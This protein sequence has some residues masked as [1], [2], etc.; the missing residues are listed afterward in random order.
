M[1][2]SRARAWRLARARPCSGWHG[3]A[4][5]AEYLVLR[6]L[7]SMMRARARGLI[8]GAPSV[9]DDVHA[10]PRTPD[11]TGSPDKARNYLPH[12][13]QLRTIRELI[14]RPD[15]LADPRVARLEPEAFTV[16]GGRPAFAAILAAARSGDTSAAE[17]RFQLERTDPTAP[18]YWTQLELGKPPKR[19]TVDAGEAARQ[20]RE[21]D[22]LRFA[23]ER[24][25]SLAIGPWPGS[26]LELEPLP[27]GFAAI[28]R[29]GPD[30]GV[31][32]LR[33]GNPKVGPLPVVGAP[34]V[35]RDAAGA[36]LSRTF[37]LALAAGEP[38]Q[39]VPWP[40]LAS[41]VCWERFSEP[42]STDRKTTEAMAAAV[43]T[44][45]AELEPVD[46]VPCWRD[47]AP[48]LP[49]DGIGPPGF[50]SL[51]PVSVAEALSTW[52]EI[53]D[54]AAA[55]PKVALALGLALG[56]IYLE[57]LG[58][59]GFTLHLQG[60][61]QRGKSTALK[62]AAAAMG[63]PGVI[64]ESFNSTLVGTGGDRAA[65]GILPQIVDELGTSDLTPRQLEID[66]FRLASG[67]GR[68]RG[69]RQTFGSVRGAGFKMARL[70]SG[71]RRIVPGSTNP[72][73]PVRE[74]DL[75][76][77]ITGTAAAAV[78][79][80]R[81]SE[82]AHG[83][84]FAWLRSAPD[85]AGFRARVDAADL[86]LGESDGGTA[87]AVA[88]S[89]AVC[90][91][92]FDWLAEQV[93]RP[94]AVGAALGAA[95]VKLAELTEELAEF[96]ATLGDQL[97]AAIRDHR[98]ANP[99]RW[100]GSSDA[101]PWG[102]QPVVGWDLIPGQVEILGSG[103]AEIAHAYGLEDT[104]AARRELAARGLGGTR[105]THR[106][107]NTHVYRFRLPELEPDDAPD[108]DESGPI[109]PPTPKPSGGLPLTG[110]AADSISTDPQ[111][112]ADS[113]PP[114]T[115]PAEP[116]DLAA[117]VDA[118]R[119]GPH[120]DAAG[121]EAV[122]AALA[123]TP[124]GDRARALAAAM[125]APDPGPPDLAADLADYLTAADSPAELR[126]RA[127]QTADVIAA[128]PEPDRLAL[129][130]VYRQR[131][132]ELRG[133]TTPT[134]RPGQ[135]AEPTNAP[136]TLP[137]EPAPAPA[138]A[139]AGP[140][141]TPT[142]DPAAQALRALRSPVPLPPGPC[143]ACGGS[144]RRTAPTQRESAAEVCADCRPGVSSTPAPI[145][146][147][148]QNRRGAA[149][150]APTPRE[151]FR[152]PS[153]PAAS[154]QAAPSGRKASSAAPRRQYVNLATDGAALWAPGGQVGEPGPW[155]DAVALALAAQ[156]AA[157]GAE[158]ILAV[159][160][161]AHLVLGLPA[162]LPTDTVPWLDAGSESAAVE[163]I[164]G[165]GWRKISTPNGVV[166]LAFPA[167]SGDFAKSADALEL[168]AAL[169]AYAGAVG[170]A[171]VFSGP[172]TVHHLIR[173][174][175]R[176]L[177]V[178]DPHPELDPAWSD[179]A[180][181]VPVGSWQRQ[182]T[183]A[184]REL[185][186]ARAYDRAGSYL[187]AWEGAALPDGPWV[188]V[189]EPFTA[190][191]GPEPK[192]PAGYWLVRRSALAELSGATLPDPF[193][194]ADPA[195]RHVWLTTPLL[196]LAVELA[197]A[198]GRS[199][200]VERAWLAAR[201]LRALDAAAV[202]LRKG[203]LA[204]KADPSP[205]AAL[206]LDV[207]KDSYARSVAWLEFAKHPPDSLARPAW[208]RTVIDRFMANTWRG[209]AKSS[210]APL[211][212]SDVDTALFLLPAADAD[213]AGL[214]LGSA[215]GSWKPKGAPAPAAAVLAALADGGTR[216]ALALLGSPGDG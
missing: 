109:P 72:G 55:N 207:L 92:G 106:G 94:A 167:W 29:D 46:S 178:P 190:P 146:G 78:A 28:V 191:T 212:Y 209:L 205:A 136:A 113:E 142:P 117:S 133:A 58:R 47:G 176:S 135:G 143:P 163:R 128:L 101:A 90:S 153:G 103:L 161:A 100:L 201:G 70:S 50:G 48:Y 6:T 188:E 127:K 112:P 17:I 214:R 98:V 110:P 213:P 173:Q 147:T 155:A 131:A 82:Q 203:R 129:R 25:K 23:R 118:Y 10:E 157:P 99:A 37:Y 185:R 22:E 152:R 115:A 125:T 43:V 130:A 160:P 66:L 7:P 65:L 206:A 86:A 79:L 150:S 3:V 57:P 89:L 194:R 91:A 158:L 210:P 166:H 169:D 76:E 5:P 8:S 74:I 20:L 24:E 18:D 68:Q 38:P 171:Y 32:L 39:P 12:A 184:E 53:V 172:S 197:T 196:Q 216:A 40:D 71:N 215:L 174:H 95:R 183:E 119:T 11:R 140:L 35:T 192:R 104:A 59:D 182:P 195:G 108:P 177:T 84:P 159:H 123:A 44:L 83:W 16:L 52:G 199:V 88:R 51:A 120:S 144:S 45:S 31:Y 179:L 13:A 14:A 56:S 41:G 80:K 139:T 69:Q 33:S 111:P 34:S 193:V 97:L 165:S 156:R 186:F 126:E 19:G 96:G 21:A 138:P 122:R 67:I 30:A 63:D 202:Q 54:L 4:H 64:L 187:S 211:A 116:P 42:I 175:S 170:L 62:V 114:V 27:G 204:L 181:A 198:Q 200:I 168:A 2:P 145:R 85:L 87:G 189:S 75:H 208:R 151:P 154:T 102:G 107:R 49:P 180:F 60:N 124:E 15:W 164:G 121:A 9:A 137:S 134:T 36:I 148:R 132:A 141:P 26:E 93:D 73:V 61:A 77:P 81:L 162:E 1:A 149:G 105:H